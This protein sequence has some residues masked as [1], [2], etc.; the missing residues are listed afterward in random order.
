MEN[1]MMSPLE[2]IFQNWLKVQ[3]PFAKETL[4]DILTESFIELVKKNYP[5]PASGMVCDEIFVERC[6]VQ[7]E[8]CFNPPHDDEHRNGELARAAA[9]YAFIAGSSDYMRQSDLIP[10][11]WPWEDEA[12]KPGDRRRELIKAAQLIVAEVERLDR[13]RAAAQHPVPLMSQSVDGEIVN[14]PRPAPFGPVGSGHIPEA[15]HGR[16]SGG[17]ERLDQVPKEPPSPMGVMITE[18]R[19]R[20][21][22]INKVPSTGSDH[23]HEITLVDS[24]R[25]SYV[26]DWWQSFKEAAGGPKY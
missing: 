19:F 20:R 22:A 6:R 8:E 7:E 17:K 3:Y 18:E 12:W 15:V 21:W 1:P 26:D 25:Q 4:I 23:G 11:G 24:E 9:C 14:V 10:P 13:D 2:A 16:A 5:F